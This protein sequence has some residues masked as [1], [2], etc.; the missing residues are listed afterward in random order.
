MIGRPFMDQAKLALL[1]SLMKID[2]RN[3]IG[4]VGTQGRPFFAKTVKDASARVG[5]TTY[6]T[7]SIVSPIIKQL[8]RNRSD[9]AP[10]ERIG[11]PTLFFSSG[12]SDDYHQPSDTVNKLSPELMA[13][14][15]RLVYDTVLA[16]AGVLTARP[17]EE[18]A[19]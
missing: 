13:R 2:S 1:K 18:S 4:V 5:L 14:R 17:L 16:L 10:F 11:I 19:T 8:A 9:H 6:G 12:P 15:A 3:G 7:Q